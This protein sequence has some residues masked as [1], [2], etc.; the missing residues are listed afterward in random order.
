MRPEANSPVS[1]VLLHPRSLRYIEG[2]PQIIM[3]KLT[4][5]F[6]GVVLLSAP[7][8]RAD[9]DKKEK[10]LPPGLRKKDKLPPGWEKKQREA[11]KKQHDNER[12]VESKPVAAPANPGNPTPDQSTA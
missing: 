6:L 5:L 9:D 2:E 7:T 10:D 12:A 8:S 3:K 4:A 11:D 1:A